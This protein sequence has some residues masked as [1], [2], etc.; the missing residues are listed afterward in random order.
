MKKLIIILISLFSALTVIGCSSQT[1]ASNPNQK[2]IIKY[3]TIMYGERWVDDVQSLL[4]SSSSKLVIANFSIENL[5]YDAFE[6]NK[7]DFSAVVKGKTYN[8][9][10]SCP[11]N[12]LLP[13]SK[14]GNGETI[15]GNVTFELPELTMDSDITWRYT[16]PG[17][18]NIEWVNLEPPPPTATQIS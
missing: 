6:T 14:I 11:A 3:S 13:D 2:I 15:K 1:S 8:Y 7:T 10:T 4:P 18:Y 12:H 5:G 17:K 16:G 9:D